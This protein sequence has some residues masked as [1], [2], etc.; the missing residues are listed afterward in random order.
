MKA[1]YVKQLEHCKLILE[2]WKTVKPWYT[3]PVIDD[4]L[5]HK[6]FDEALTNSRLGPPYVL[7]PFVTAADVKPVV[8]VVPSVA[9]VNAKLVPATT[10]S[11]ATVD[12]KLVT[13]TTKSVT[14]V[15]MKLVPVVVNGTASAD[16][17]VVPVVVP[18]LLPA[19]AVPTPTDAKVAPVVVK[20]VI[21]GGLRLPRLSNNLKDWYDF[22]DYMEECDE[23]L[24]VSYDGDEL[25]RKLSIAR[26][27]YWEGWAAMDD[28]RLYSILHPTVS[29]GTIP[30]PVDMAFAN[31]I[32][33][34]AP[35]PDEPD[36]LLNEFKDLW[37]WCMA[38]QDVG[39]WDELLD[40]FDSWDKLWTE[41]FKG[42]KLE[43][44]RRH[45]FS[46]VWNAWLIERGVTPDADSTPSP[47]ANFV[48]TV[49]PVEPM[50]MAVEGKA[51]VEL[52]KLILSQGQGKSCTLIIQNA[53]PVPGG[54]SAPD[55]AP[56][57]T[58]PTIDAEPAPGSAPVSK[59]GGKR[60]R[61][62]RF[63]KRPKV[64][65]SPIAVV[66]VV[67]TVPVLDD[68]VMKAAQLAAFNKQVAHLS[69]LKVEAARASVVAELQAKQNEAE[70][71][72]LRIAAKAIL[73][74]RLREQAAVRKQAAREAMAL[75]VQLELIKAKEERQRAR[76]H[77]RTEF[78]ASAARENAE[79]E[80]K[81][82]AVLSTKAE[83]QAE[84]VRILKAQHT[85][86]VWKAHCEAK[87]RYQ[88]LWAW[89]S[90]VKRAAR[91]L[92][93]AQAQAAMEQARYD[94]IAAA[95]ART[96]A[97]K[98]K[99]AEMKELKRGAHISDKQAHSSKC[100]SADAVGLHYG[101]MYFGSTFIGGRGCRSAWNCVL[102]S[103]PNELKLSGLMRLKLKLWRLK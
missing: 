85:W 35:M 14:A 76:R 36:T 37:S 26:T 63:K 64:Y 91:T 95:N 12:A 70:R 60:W 27:D 71:Q 33:G 68:E 18:T 15:N 52:W 103:W 42:K 40:R 99:Y 81:A 7:E 84:R 89:R 87:H 56:G 48:P 69:K 79:R 6:E 17:K 59:Q 23:R 77:R 21:H 2:R 29:S 51:D 72:A 66:P 45:G 62:R 58:P 82:Q 30:T 5:L 16:A 96:V 11:V 19:E 67:I 83:I 101:P 55:A 22:N 47:D 13:T 25:K 43:R 44:M 31:M 4:E 10:K 74:E 75:E 92:A 90:N 102:I 93:Y 3:W 34:P 9:T 53:G 46:T 8:V 20:N 94:A 97:K 65:E 28:I 57:P 86:V 38:D 39:S 61:A 32:P 80:V 54:G 88:G 50:L 1:K 73:G 78:K 98:R 24:A 49:P 100:I 41:Y